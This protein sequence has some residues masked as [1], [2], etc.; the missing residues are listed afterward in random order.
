MTPDDL[1][2]IQKSAGLSDYQLADRLGCS[3]QHIQRMKMAPGKRGHRPI[4]PHIAEKLLAL[5]SNGME[6]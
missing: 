6:D 1:R 2:R 5:R 3:P 4:M